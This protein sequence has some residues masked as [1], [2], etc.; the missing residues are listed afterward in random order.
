[1]FLEKK[2]LGQGWKIDSG[3]KIES[4]DNVYGDTSVDGILLYTQQSFPLRP[5]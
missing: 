3:K 1:M 4:A 2:C 5:T